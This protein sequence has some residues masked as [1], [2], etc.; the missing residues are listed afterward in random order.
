MLK[1]LDQLNVAIARTDD[2]Q[3]QRDL[4]I[5]CAGRLEGCDLHAG[6][7]HGFEIFHRQR[8]REGLL[9]EELIQAFGLLQGAGIVRLVHH[10]LIAL[11]LLPYA[12]RSCH[13]ANDRGRGLL[14]PSGEQRAG[15]IP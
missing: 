1:I 14:L 6:G 3:S 10:G 12:A 13:R 9:I 4:A 11:P 5:L 15:P 8:P 2:A 7:Q